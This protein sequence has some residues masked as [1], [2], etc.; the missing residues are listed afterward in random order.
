MTEAMRKMDGKWAL[1]YSIIVVGI[2][3]LYAG[4]EGLS[5]TNHAGAAAAQVEANDE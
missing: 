1:I 5:L 3:L 2:M 4:S